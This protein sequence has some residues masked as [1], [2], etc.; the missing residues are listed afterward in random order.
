MDIHRELKPGLL[1]QSSLAIGFFDGVHLGH[2]A[3]IKKAIDESRRLG[4]PAGVLTFADHPRTRTL[5]R[6]PALLTLLD[7]R[8]ELFASLGVDATIVLDFNDELCRMRAREYVEFVLIGALGARSVSVGFNHHFGR[9]REGS[10]ALL[11]RLG[12]ELGFSVNIVPPVVI[13]GEEVSSSR[14]RN[15]LATGGVEPARNLLGR[16]YC[17][18]SKVVR[19]DGRGHLLGFATANLHISEDQILP[20]TGVYA[21]MSWTPSDS[22]LPSVVNIGYRPTVTEGSKLTAEV[23]ILDYSGELYDRDIAVEFWRFL[24]SET[25]FNNVGDLK[26]QISKDCLTARQLLPGSSAGCTAPEKTFKT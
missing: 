8:L 15:L 7:Q 5:G 14:I 2:Q 4:A 16:P 23:H 12:D 22:E 26:R 3:V 13:D 21:G 6:S 10:A 24:R 25:R 11:S 9:D 19:G 18:T 1:K 20:C 17:L